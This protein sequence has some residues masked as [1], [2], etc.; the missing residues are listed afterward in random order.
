MR[1]FRGIL[2]AIASSAT[3]GLIPLFSIPLLKAGMAPPSILFYRLGFAAVMMGAIAVASGRSLRIGAKDATVLAGLGALYLGTSLGLLLSYRYIPSGV[4]T[5]IH[6]LYPL[7]VALAM[8]LFFGERSSGRLILAIALSL[9]GV[10]LLSWG[11]TGSDAPYKGVL[12]ASCT[13]FTY[14]IYIITVMKSRVAQMDSLVLT[15]YILLFG[16]LCFLL[17]A[18]ATTG[19]IDP[20]RS[21]EEWLNALMLAAVPTVFSNLTLVMAIKRIGST[22]TSI[23]GS[24]EP[25]TAVAVGVVRFDEGFGPRSAVGLVLV[26]TAVILVILQSRPHPRHTLAQSK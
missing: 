9:G 18:L 6:F 14:A 2:F 7:V 19:R 5:T 24:M 22:M 12:L 26:L 21:G 1:R 4:T 23:L 13:V 11:D 17:A 15:F 25:L 20:I 10:G 16:A 8:I 3:F